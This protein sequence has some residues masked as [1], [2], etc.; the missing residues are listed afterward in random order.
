MIN[1]KE[2]SLLKNFIGTTD[3]LM[4]VNLQ[5]VTDN[6]L[7]T[8]NDIFIAIVGK[9]FNPLEHLDKVYESG[10]RF[11]I[12][13]KN[14]AN[15]NLVQG[16]IE[17][18]VFV[19]VKNIEEFI[20]EA[21]KVVASKFKNRGGSIIAISGSNGKTTTK[22]ML[23]HI[24]SKSAGDQ[25]VICTQ[26]NFNNHLG[27]P[28]TLF[29]INEET[30][31][32]IVELGSNHPGEIK[33]LCEILKPQYGVTTNIGDTHL[34]FFQNR[35]N[36][37]KEEGIL[38]KY[39]GTK[40]FLNMDDELLST[41]APQENLHSYG[42]TSNQE[43]LGFEFN[44]VSINKVVVKNNNITGQHNFY[45]LA[46]AF[47]IA[48]EVL[49]D[50]SEIQEHAETFIPTKNRS[51]WLSVKNQEIY[52]DAYNAN[53]SSMILAVK[54]FADHLGSIGAK[55]SESCL[56]IGDMN[57]LGVDAA[58]YHEALGESLNKFKFGKI[59]FVGRH[60][61]DYD[62]KFS[63]SSILLNTSI[64]VKNLY[65][66]CIAEYKYVFIKGSRSLQL[67]TIL[68]IS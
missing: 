51:E 43:K 1:L 13:E 39:A 19:K 2:L 31:Y 22:E 48:R 61:S 26:K 62:K 9:K 54:G 65:N 28:F 11:V 10:C 67:E 52:L 35:E 17:K 29:Q 5:L 53:P 41:I 6:R 34:E 42:I 33:V 15:D 50:P 66:E 60:A 24:L 55:Q 36:V 25:R 3:R 23:F 14:D 47:I 4:N 68:D 49:E 40:F 32:A 30:K 58:R 37:F 64:E 46:V 12:Y 63:G 45:N 7:L 21:G 20:Q 27:V 44:S 8:D 59:I 57:E 16:H 56:I 18:L 38:H